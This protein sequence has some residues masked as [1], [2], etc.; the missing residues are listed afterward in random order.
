MVTTVSFASASNFSVG[1]NG[2]GNFSI[3]QG[4]FN[5]DGLIDLAVT[6]NQDGTVSVLLGD[7]SG[8]FGSITSYTV[9]STP[10]SVVVG[11]FDKDGKVDLIVANTLGN[12]VTP[13]SG[14]GF[15]NF[16]LS[17]SNFSVG[18]APESLAVGDFDGDNFDDFV[19][20]NAADDTVSVLLSSDG[21][22]LTFTVGDNPQSVAVGD[23]DKDNDLDLVVANL[24]TNDVTVLF[25]AGSGSVIS[26][27]FSV[28][29]NP[30]SVAVKDFNGDGFLDLV[31]ANASSNNV[32][33]LLNDGSGSFGS[34]INFS[35][36]SNPQLVAVGDF[37]GDGFLDLATANKDSQNV[38]VL[39]NDGSGSFGSAMNF[40]VGSSPQSLTLGDFN[41]DGKLD[42][43]VANF[44]SNNLSILLNNTIID[45]ILPPPPPPV[46]GGTTGGTVTVVNF[47]NSN[48]DIFK[49]GGDASIKIK[50][51]I[52]IKGSSSKLVN[53]LGIFSVDD[54]QGS[55]DGV[56]PGAAGYQEKAL[57]RSKIIFSV[58]ANKPTGFSSDDLSRILEFDGGTQI[59]FY[60]KSQGSIIFSS[61]TSQK[62]T[63]LSEGGFTLGWK[64]GSRLDSAFDDLEIDVKETDE[65]LPIGTDLQ[66]ESEGECIDLS[67]YGS[68]SLFSGTFTVNREATYSNYVGFYQVTDSDGG[69]DT[70]GDGTADILP[71]QAGYTQA[72]LN[73][74]L[75][76][77]G[78]T[79]ANQG[80]GK[81]NG[82]FKGGGIYVP[83]LIV[84]GGVE[85]LLDSNSGND[86]TVYFTFLGANKDKTQHVKMLGDNCF[87][88]EDLNGGG[89]NDFNDVTVKLNLTISA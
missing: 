53:E 39:L 48:D 26:S 67:E 27:N 49:F 47:T 78:L 19:V 10:Q 15:G 71:G 81:G 14:D 23:F 7:G 60:L 85:S 57:E 43:A 58:I 63:S 82:N 5:G 3:T 86:P 25:N 66:G 61:S 6:N 50:I 80:Q 73:S 84:D 21:S 1:S 33:V 75:S 31:T 56:A 87:G 79:V 65:D 74:R 76:E 69:I 68:D 37:N 11:D 4:D 59:R 40:S 17:G 70:N 72:A 41:G 29:S 52:K 64:D 83:F 8:S 20:A 44:G 45:P 42:L 12:D 62:I 16:T 88:F 89:D 9:G 24:V 46:D 28:G 36:G 55:I 51:K 13:L 77:I 32:S 30:E 35:V 18:G 22:L 34:A 2:S 38:S 54:S